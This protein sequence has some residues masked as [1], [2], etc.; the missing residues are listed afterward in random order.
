MGMVDVMTEA[1]ALKVY[2][3]PSAM[4]NLKAANKIL[5]HMSF[6]KP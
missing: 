5:L 1:M 2:F 6:S 3:P 4:A